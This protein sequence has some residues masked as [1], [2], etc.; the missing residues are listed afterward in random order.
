MATLKHSKDT[1][2]STKISRCALCG[3]YANLVCEAFL[4]QIWPGGYGCLLKE[5]S[6]GDFNFPF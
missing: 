1:Q 5:Y 6:S 2:D 4:K 3:S